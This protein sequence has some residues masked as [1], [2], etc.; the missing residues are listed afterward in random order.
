LQSAEF[1]YGSLALAVL[2]FAVLWRKYSS[3]GA[4]TVF[5]VAA[6]PPSLLVY[7]F[8]AN[9]GASGIQETLQIGALSEAVSEAAGSAAESPSPPVAV[10]AI[11]LLAAA[12]IGIFAFRQAGTS[13]DADIDA[14]EEERDEDTLEAVGAA[15]GRAA[16]RIE[17]YADVDNEVYRAWREMASLIDADSPQTSTAGEFADTA[18]EAG[19]DRDD[20]EELTG[21]F[22]EVRYGDA[23]A[24]EGR[25]QRALDALRRVEEEYGE[26]SADPAYDGP[27]GGD[28]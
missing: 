20:I 26:P 25:E 17:R 22:E 28:G 2:T 3:K 11:V 5:F 19:M 13:G 4:I 16:D 9:C 1:L 15:A 18:I 27:D 10:L 24:A 12:L 6:T 14:D 8:L 21:L 7:A 23:D